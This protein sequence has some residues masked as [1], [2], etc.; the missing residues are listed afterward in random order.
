VL[1]V[2]CKGLGARE[3]ELA[4]VVSASPAC[5]RPSGWWVP[6]QPDGRGGAREA[7][8]ALAAFEQ[9]GARLDIDA[10]TRLAADLSAPPS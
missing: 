8:A 9:I 10:A 4:R 3:L 2:V 5:A 7:Q 1:V 6:V